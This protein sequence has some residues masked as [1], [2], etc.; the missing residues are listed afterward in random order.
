M[1]NFWLGIIFSGV[2]LLLGAGLNLALT[3]SAGATSP[4]FMTHIRPSGLGGALHESVIIFNESEEDTDITNWC[5]K[6][7]AGINFFCFTPRAVNERVYLSPQGHAVIVSAQLRAIL[8]AEDLLWVY[9]PTH[10]S[11]GSLV[12]TSGDV[13]LLDS[14][15]EIVDRHAWTTPLVTGQSFA[16]KL[17]VGEQ[18][19]YVNTGALSDWA[20]VN[21][22]YSLPADTTWHEITELPEEEEIPPS[23]EEPVEEVTPL[24]S[25][26]PIQLSEV[27]PNPVGSDV[28]AEFIELYNANDSE[29]DISGYVLEIGIGTT[30]RI[31]LKAGT[32]VAAKS[33]VIIT[34]AV[35]SYSLNNTAGGVKLLKPEGDLLVDQTAYQDPAEGASWIHTGGEWRY[36]SLPTPLA[37][38]IV[39]EAL[40][41]EGAITI[42][43]SEPKPCAEGQYRHP[44]THRCRKIVEPIASVSCKVGQERNPETGRCR[45]IAAVSTATSCKEGQERNPETN[46]CRN[47]VGMSDA[48]HKVLGVTEQKSSGISWY[49]WAAAIL[50]GAAILG[51]A[52]WEWRVEVRRAFGWVKN[53]LVSR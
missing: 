18:L 3:D 31:T 4:I 43:Q 53:R 20:I 36:T 23:E 48:G 6:N 13:M 37:E 42:A 38:N 22:D 50:A 49:I 39:V 52:A 28:G 47:I 33:Y 27:F 44:E 26:V 17:V 1:K 46:R 10:A 30:K 35:F 19:S 8:P 25:L 29:L 51:Y 34:N 16:R 7:K 11:S 40:E 2:V 12:A 14:L 15:S 45:N 41:E 21:G 24:P 32:I 5:L 9:T